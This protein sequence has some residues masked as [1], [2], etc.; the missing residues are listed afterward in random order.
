ANAGRWAHAMDPWKNGYRDLPWPEEAKQQ[1]A[2]VDNY[3]LAAPEG[4]EALEQWM[5][6]LTY[7]EFLSQ[8]VGVTREEVFAYL[9]PQIAAYGTGMGCDTISALAARVF[10]AP[11]TMTAEEIERDR[12]RRKKPELDFEPVSF[13]GGNGAIARYLVKRLI[14]DALGGGDSLAD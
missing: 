7:R 1:L 9:E 13:P 5:D 8:K 2:R 3:V 10:R 4:D 11:A 6:T 12:N 14:P